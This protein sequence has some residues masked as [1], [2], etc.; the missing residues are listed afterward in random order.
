MATSDSDEIFA[1]YPTA[2]WKPD[3]GKELFFAVKSLQ[4]TFRN[5]IVRHKRIYR[6]GARLDDTGTDAIE[7]H[8]N[9]LFFND[10]LQQE[11][12]LDGETQYPDNANALCDSFTIHETGTLTTPTR[13]PRRCRAETYE[14]SET[15]DVRDAAQI[16][17]TWVE[18]NEDDAKAAAFT[19]PSAKSVSVSIAAAAIEACA[20]AGVTSDNLGTFNEFMDALQELAESPGDYVSDLESKANA[21]LGKIKQT[22]ESFTTAASQASSDHQ[23]MLSDPENS[24]ALRMLRRAQDNS[25]RMIVEVIAA[26]QPVIKQVTFTV[27]RDIFD[28][29][30][31]YD[32]DASA[33][34]KLNNQLA[35]LLFI[36]AGTPVKI[37]DVAA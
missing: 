28:I 16:N 24:L 15:S 18:D 13:G 27:A 31:Q 33:L 22:E 32:Q 10:T 8:L 11:Q 3:T 29:A 25:A 2:S 36:A 7:W 14:R 20:A 1:K 37:F 9:C 6:D 34:M 30:A 5:R 12:G 21:A 23:R 17:F 26:T 35:D 4:E 19:A